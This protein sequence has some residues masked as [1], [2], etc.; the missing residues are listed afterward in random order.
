[1]DKTEINNE[2]IRNSKALSEDY[3]SAN[4]CENFQSFDLYFKKKYYL[5]ISF[6]FILL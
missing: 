4:N 5:N 1:M 2:L 6:L 3:D